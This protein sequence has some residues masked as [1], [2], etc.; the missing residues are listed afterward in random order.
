LHLDHREA[1]LELLGLV[2]REVR[3]FS[4]PGMIS[5]RFAH[6]LAAVAHAQRE[7]CPLRWKNAANSSRASG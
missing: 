1:R 4:A 7:R 6:H 5:C 2:A 3:Q